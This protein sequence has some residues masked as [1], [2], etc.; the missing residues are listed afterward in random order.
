[1]RRF[2]AAVTSRMAWTQP[3]A[4]RPSGRHP[5]DGMVQVGA[6]GLAAPDEPGIARL[7][8]CQYSKRDARY[9]RSTSRSIILSLT[10]QAENDQS[11]HGSEDFT[12]ALDSQA[13][14]VALR[15]AAR[16]SAGSLA[17]SDGVAAGPRADDGPRRHLRPAACLHERLQHLVDPGLV[18]GAKAAEEPQHIGIQPQADR[19]FRFP[20]VE[21]QIRRPGCPDR[22]AT[23]R[24]TGG[25]FAPPARTRAFAACT[26]RPLD[27]AV[28]LRFVFAIVAS[29]DDEAG[30]FQP[31]VN[32]PAWVRWRAHTMVYARLWLQSSG[33]FQSHDFLAT[34][35][36]FR[37]AA[38]SGTARTASANE[39]ADRQILR[40]C[41]CGRPRHPS[42]VPVQA[43]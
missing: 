16:P 4:Y 20:H 41:R 15:Q 5:N 31:R 35:V 9:L 42:T 2:H 13:D 40:R 30:W 34:V 3:R 43:S 38:R 11:L 27:D 21:H 18:T 19:Q 12:S 8:E 28:S 39:P 17:L 6:P 10:V 37:S 24:A 14:P 33:R 25:I 36:A 29:L 1:M 26:E 32:A 23:E 7:G 22:L